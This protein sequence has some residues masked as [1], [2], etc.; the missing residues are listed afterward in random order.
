[1]GKLK[2]QTSIE[3]LLLFGVLLTFGLGIFII[4]L[5]S[6]AI[7]N[8]KEAR[9]N[10]QRISDTLENEISIALKL[11]DGYERVFTLLP[12]TAR[13]DFYTISVEGDGLIAIDWNGGSL[14]SK[15]PTRALTDGSTDVFKISFGANKI[16][17]VDG[18]IIIQSV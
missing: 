13:L 15:M 2:S 18:V 9:V 11:G 10:A 4:N 8:A 1:M 5:D 7:I 3:L 14:F 12:P 16:S 6:Q 17:N